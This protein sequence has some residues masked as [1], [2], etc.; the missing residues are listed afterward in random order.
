MEKISKAGRVAK[1]LKNREEMYL[2][3]TLAPEE[4]CRGVLKVKKVIGFLPIGLVVRAPGIM[5]GKIWFSGEA[6]LKSRQCRFDGEEIVF[7]DRT[8]VVVVENA[9]TRDSVLIGFLVNGE[10]LALGN[11]KGMGKRNEARVQGS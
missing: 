5:K 3:F 8:F 10:T 2:T 6:P 1:V 4:Y 9:S 7:T 11:K